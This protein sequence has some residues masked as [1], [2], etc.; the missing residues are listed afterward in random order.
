MAEHQSFTDFHQ[1]KRPGVVAPIPRARLR[2]AE[3][4]ERREPVPPAEFNPPQRGAL[5]HK[6]IPV[7][8]GDANR[9]KE[10]PEVTGANRPGPVQIGLQKAE[11]ELRES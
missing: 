4:R 1:L 7:S 2:T 5:G 3:R 6:H 8:T 9:R 10:A 11:N